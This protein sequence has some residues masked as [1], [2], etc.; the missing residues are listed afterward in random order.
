MNLYKVILSQTD[1]TEKIQFTCENIDVS[2]LN[3]STHNAIT[4]LGYYQLDTNDNYSLRSLIID[5]DFNF[6]NELQLTIKNTIKSEIRTNKL[7][8]ILDIK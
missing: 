5:I 3:I 8:T 4:A 1:T 6:T 2:M 7:N